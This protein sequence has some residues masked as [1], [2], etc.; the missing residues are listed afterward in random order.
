[1]LMKKTGLHARGIGM[2]KGD[3]IYVQSKDKMFI[4]VLMY[5]YIIIYIYKFINLWNIEGQKSPRVPRPP[6]PP[7][8]KRERDVH[9]VLTYSI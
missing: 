7:L 5:I 3:S 4:T 1:M 2:R 6:S 8:L 9:E